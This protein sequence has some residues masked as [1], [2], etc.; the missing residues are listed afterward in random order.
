MHHISVNEES[1]VREAESIVE[2]RSGHST[3]CSNCGAG[4]FESRAQQTAH[5][6][7]HWH[8]H[9]LRRR[10][11][12]KPAITLLQFNAR[13]GILAVLFCNLTYLT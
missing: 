11:L 10:L 7:H 13:K 9:N 4:P 2:N 6:K 12:G 8:T 5:Y 1:V 3:G